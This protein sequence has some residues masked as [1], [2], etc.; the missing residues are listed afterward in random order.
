MTNVNYLFYNPCSIHL[1]ITYF[2]KKGLVTRLILAL[3]CMHLL[4]KF[5]FHL[6][7]FQLKVLKGFDSPLNNSR[8][9]LKKSKLILK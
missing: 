7:G 8:Q 1:S 4:E 2:L 9:G 3:Q 6:G 5:S